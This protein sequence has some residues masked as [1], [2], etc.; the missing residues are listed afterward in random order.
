ML[1]DGED[2]SLGVGGRKLPRHTP[3]MVAVQPLACTSSH[4]LISYISGFLFLQIFRRCQLVMNIMFAWFSL[5]FD[6]IMQVV[7]VAKDKELKCH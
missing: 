6:L 5:L 2:T 7:H 3:N 4:G 1:E